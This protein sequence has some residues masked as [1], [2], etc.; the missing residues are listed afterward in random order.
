MTTATCCGIGTNC[1]RTNQPH[2]S[3]VVLKLIWDAGWRL[4]WT[5]VLK[6]VLRT[7]RLQLRMYKQAAIVIELGRLL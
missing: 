1:M 5:I 6:S 2:A 4:H 7:K 3:P